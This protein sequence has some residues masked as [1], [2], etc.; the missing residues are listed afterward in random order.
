MSKLSNPVLSAEGNYEETWGILLSTEASYDD[1]EEVFMFITEF[2]Q[3]IKAASQ[4][5][6]DP[7]TAK[8]ILDSNEPKPSTSIIELAEKIGE[9]I[10]SGANIELPAAPEDLSDNAKTPAKQLNHISRISVRSDKLDKLMYLVSELFTTKSELQIASNKGDLAHVKTAAEKIEKLATQFRHNALSIRLV[11]LKELTLKFKRL[12]RDLSQS[13]NKIV[14]F[15]IEGDETELDKNLVDSL[16][17]PFMHLIRNC[18]D[19]GIEMPA[20][21]LK[22]GKAEQGTVKFSAYQSGNFIYIQ[23]SDDGNGIDIEYIKKKAIE[24][25]FIQ[26]NSQLSNREL[27]DLIFLPGFSTAESLTQISGRGVGMDVVKRSITELRGSVEIETEKGQG[28][29]FTIKLQQTISIMDTL[30]IKA[31]NTYFTIILEEVEICGLEK[32]ADL[33][34][35]NNSHWQLGDELIPFVYLREAF[36]LKGN[37]PESEKIV[38]V[39]KQNKRFAIVAD[40]IVG[41][42]QAVLKPVGEIFKSQEFI[43][44]ASV[45]GDGNIALM[46]DTNR[47]SDYKSVASKQL[48]VSKK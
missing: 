7:S 38:V 8:E 28:T 46:L 11:P 5:L 42:Y 9:A 27:L 4:D 23:I 14:E 1:I 44:G 30:L 47:L 43:S 21:R 15:D 3:I 2:V 13:L 10:E 35:R 25:G 36:K 31:E 12:I 17:D 32:H 48:A 22:K 33:F 26:P 37:S 40:D 16:A 41:Q 29:T 45:M 20:D 18:I 34:S 19:H 24:K 6:L 39:R